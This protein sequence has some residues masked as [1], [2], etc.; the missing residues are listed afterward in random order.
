MTDPN[1]PVMLAPS[2][3]YTTNL[4]VA[5]TPLEIIGVSGHR[6]RRHFT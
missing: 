5:Y 3:P 2:Y 4:D 6:R 1:P